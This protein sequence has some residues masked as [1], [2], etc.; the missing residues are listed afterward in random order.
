MRTQVCD[1]RREHRGML[2]N[3]K[4]TATHFSVASGDMREVQVCRDFGRLR[5]D[6][7]RQFVVVVMR[8]HSRNRTWHRKRIPWTPFRK[9]WV[10][11]TCWER[12]YAASASRL[13]GRVSSFDPPQYFFLSLSNVSQQTGAWR[14]PPRHGIAALQPK[15]FNQPA[16]TQFERN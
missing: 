12:S 6:L 8:E 1:T 11:P 5:R 3:R 16:C 9:L 15:L 14:G 4:T 10:G 13:R 7:E 2:T